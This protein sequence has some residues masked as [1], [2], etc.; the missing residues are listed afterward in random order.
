M[1]SRKPDPF[2]SV[3]AAISALVLTMGHA[4]AHVTLA[5]PQAVPAARYMAH[6]RV[7][8]GCDGSPTVALRIELPPDVSAVTPQPQPGWTLSTE[9]E[10]SRIKTVTWTGG[11]LPPDQHGLFAIAMTLPDREGQLLF[12]ARQ[13][14][15]TGE[16]YWSEPSPTSGKAK[17][18]APVL[19]VSAAAPMPASVAV[20]EGWFRALPP[21]VPSGGYFTLRNTGTKPLTL[22]DVET[23][24][25]GMV[26]M[27][28]SSNGGMEH[29]MSLEVAAGE[30]VT[31]A[32]GGYHLMCMDTKPALKPG[33]R[34]PVTFHFAGN[35]DVTAT[36][37]V[38]N[39][40]GK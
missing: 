15:Q 21:S 37:D 13:T 30:T 29:V 5:E 6:F 17:H 35:Q 2:H 23:P 32:P 4:N 40:T 38:R 24:A 27:H 7:G 34:V 26:M 36:F 28:K 11:M 18:P 3:T 12:P 9:R 14:C 31:F 1:R 22:T 39:A 20:T 10:G 25:C 16:E 8:H 33:A 19:T